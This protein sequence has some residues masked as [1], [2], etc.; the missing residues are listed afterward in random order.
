MYVVRPFIL[1]DLNTR[2]LIWRIP[3]HEKVIYLTFDDGPIPELTPFI[4]ET[5][6]KHNAKAT[7]FCVGDNI[8]KYPDLKNQILKDGHVIGNHTF[9]HFDGWK[10]NSEEYLQNVS[11][12]FDLGSSRMFRPPY[13][14][15]TPWQINR[16]KNMSYIVLWTV[17]S[18]DY[19]KNT[20]PARCL[21]NVLRCT[22]R[23]SIVVFH[24][25]IKATPRIKY[26]LPRVLEHYSKQGYRFEVLS[27]EVLQKA[28]RHNWLNA[29]KKFV[30]KMIGNI[31]IPFV[32]G[33][34]SG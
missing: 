28:L 34:V 7:F 26:A 22:R 1:K 8:Q 13:G 2:N 18:Y 10:K 25:N 9:N 11:K 16:V 3:G 19:D 5:L 29:S 27:E 23:G 31:N 14:H 24:D 20:T 33:K 6:K 15:I 12:G 30:N 4:L 21:H 17:L 32:Y